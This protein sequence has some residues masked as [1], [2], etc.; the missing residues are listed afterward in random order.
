MGGAS[1][2][3]GGDTEVSGAEAVAT[4]YNPKMNKKVLITT[5]GDTKVTTAKDTEKFKQRGYDEVMDSKMPITLTPFRKTLAKNAYGNRDYFNTKVAGG[6]GYTRLDGTHISKTA[7]EQMSATEQDQIYGEYMDDR[8]AGRTDAR[9][10]P[11]SCWRRE[12]IKHKT[13][14]GYVDKAVWQQSGRND[15]FGTDREIKYKTEEQIAK[16]NKTGVM[17][18]PTGAEIDQ[19]SATT[20]SADETLL[21]T[22]KKGRSSNILTSATGLGGT[23]LNIKKKTLG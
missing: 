13:K 16:E 5:Y 17:L 2:K 18:S 22:N 21:A 15:D 10:N 20:M 19:A 14:D 6:K 12:T 9:G 7:F 8:M 23:N 11:I 1:S 3:G 4:K